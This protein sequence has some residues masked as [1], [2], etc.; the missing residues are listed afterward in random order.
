MTRSKYISLLLAVLLV[1]T[2]LVFPFSAKAEANYSILNNI[3]QQYY[4]RLLGSLARADYY[5]TDVLASVTAAQAIYEGGWGAYSLPVGGNNLFGIKAYSSWDGKVYDQTAST[6]YN[7]YGD[8]LLSLGQLRSNEVSAWR[9]HDSWAESVRVHSNLFLES[10][11]YSAVIGETDYTAALQAIV[12]GGYCNDNGY[13]EE[14]VGILERYGLDYY[15][16]ITPDEDGV[17]ALTASS[18]RVSL[19]IGDTHTLSLTYYPASATPS[20]VTWASDNKAVATVNKNGKITA[21]S[22]GTALIT[23]T[24]ANGREACCI[25]YVDTNAT[26][27]DENVLVRES[28]S[29]DA[30]Y[31]GKFYR[32]APV[33]VTSEAIYTDGKG[34][35]YVAVTGYNNNDELVSG[36]VLSEYVYRRERNVSSITV[37]KDD[38]TLTPDQ[39]YTVVTSVAP[40]DAVDAALTWASSDESIAT[41]NEKGVITAKAL[42]TAVI[43][44]SAAGGASKAITVTVAEAAKNYKGI[45]SV[46]DSLRIRAVAAWSASSLGTAEFL[47]EVTVLGEPNGYWYNVKATTTSGKEVTGY[48]FSTY[49]KL[50]PEGESVSQGKTTTTLSV[51]ENAN[52][53]AKKVGALASDTDIA[54]IGA[55]KDGWSYVIGKSASGD[56]LYGY[57]KLD[58]SGEIIGDIGAGEQISGWYGKVTSESDLNVRDSASESGEIVG[59]FASGTQIIITAEEQDGWYA[60]YGESVDGEYV[61]GYSSAEYIATLYKGVVINI[62]DNLNVRSEPSTAGEII[63]KLQNDNEV[64]IIGEVQ[65]NWY[66]IE[67]DDLNGY[68]SADYIQVNG[69]I[70]VETNNDSPDEPIDYGDF[71]ITDGSLIL[72]NGVLT[73][74]SQD[75]TVSDLMNSFTGNVAILDKSGNKLENT[76]LVATGCQLSVTTNGATVTVA[77]VAV[78]GDV[79]GDGD[80]TATD[81][82]LVKR[83]FFGTYKLESIYLQAAL[84][85]SEDKL[86]IVDYVIIKRAYFGTY[87]L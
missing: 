44:A 52:T 33:K 24:L 82:V 65:N 81:Y 73:G 2:T 26:I 8:F 54:V 39:K 53:S 59:Q 42:G 35:E 27:I 86:N 29:S 49:L 46:A 76:A 28:P 66:H 75:T 50:I 74:V 84:V 12:D 19:N 31:N 55:E 34:N 69:K 85:S 64:T 20:K 25:V 79:D 68:C 23:A 45:V 32:G 30:E 61:K 71:S 47:S 56:A 36:Y 41:V 87:N 51:Y 3:H 6:L 18:E 9:A 62:D 22:H 43:T 7:S 5:E 13:V 16:D 80:I 1:F 77:T 15:D 17:V 40:A 67:T 63:G 72:Q 60:V 83:C 10:S 78:S 14:A 37:V 48:V 21:V 57:V 38:I 58:G 11:N 4:L 70:T